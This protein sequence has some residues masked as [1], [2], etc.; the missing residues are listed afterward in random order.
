[1]VSRDTWNLFLG[2]FGILIL[3]VVFPIMER[4]LPFMPMGMRVV[5]CAPL[6]PVGLWVGWEGLN[7][8]DWRNTSAVHTAQGVLRMLFGAGM[9]TVGLFGLIV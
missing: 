5:L 7:S 4:K 8:G 2:A 6:M 9:T 1:M 3:V